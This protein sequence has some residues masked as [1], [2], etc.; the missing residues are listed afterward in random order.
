ME[1]GESGKGKRSM[2]NGGRV[3]KREGGW[4]GG[5]SEFCVGEMQSFKC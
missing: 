2:W 3:G 1:N 5:G 4:G